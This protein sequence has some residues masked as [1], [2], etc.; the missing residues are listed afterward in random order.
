MPN[1]QESLDSS[2]WLCSTHIFRKS[3]GCCVGTVGMMWHERWPDAKLQ[4]RP[5]KWREV[6]KTEMIWKERKDYI[7]TAAVWMQS[8]AVLQ[9]F[10]NCFYI[11]IINISDPD[12]RS[13]LP[14]TT[15]YVTN[16]LVKSH[17]NTF[18]RLVHSFRM[19][20]LLWHLVQPILLATM[21]A[22]CCCRQDVHLAHERVQAPSLRLD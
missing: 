15:R 2:R 18:S 12:H 7:S 3:L 22:N 16:C 13:T 1:T 21:G 8:P 19:L 10:T 9:L 14:M 6:G 5:R 4:W 20:T 11:Y 17:Q